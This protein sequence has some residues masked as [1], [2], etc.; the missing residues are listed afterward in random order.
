MRKRDCLPPWVRSSRRPETRQSADAQGPPRPSQRRDLLPVGKLLASASTNYKTIRIWGAGSGA[1]SVGSW[2]KTVKLWNAGSG[3][4]R[5]TLKSHSGS[6]TAAAS[7][8]RRRLSK[9]QLGCGTPTRERCYRRLRAIWV[10]FWRVAFSSDGKLL[11]SASEDSAV[12]LWDVGFRR[13]HPQLAVRRE[14]C[15]GNRAQMAL[16][17]L[18]Y[19]SPSVSEDNT[20]RL[21]DEG[22]GAALQALEGQSVNY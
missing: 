18:H 21:W 20:T 14:C 1:T 6:V 7:S 9:R 12:K 16:E 5:Q 13:Q 3:A 8:W 4:V 19:R 17:R 11:A 10:G 15:R 2:D 22:S